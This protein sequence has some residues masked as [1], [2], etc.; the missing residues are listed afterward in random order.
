MLSGP[1]GGWTNG[2]FQ[3]QDMNL[4]NHSKILI[5]PGLQN[6]DQSQSSNR[7]TLIIEFILVGLRLSSTQ[8]V[9]RFHKVLQMKRVPTQILSKN[10]KTM[11]RANQGRSPFL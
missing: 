7:S 4:M 3:T 6:C 9:T 11:D 1:S 5:I 10:R 8:T 2:P